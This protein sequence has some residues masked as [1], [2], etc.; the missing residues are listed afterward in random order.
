M[1]SLSD[2]V[3]QIRAIYDSADPAQID[4]ELRC[5]IGLDY[6]AD[7]NCTLEFRAPKEMKP[8]ILIY[9]ELDNFHQNHRSYSKSRN[10]FQL[11]GGDADD[12]AVEACMPLTKLG[13][14]TLNPCGKIANTYFNDVFY[15]ST[16]Q[17]EDGAPLV[18]V[19]EGIAWQSDIQYRFAQPDGFRMK[20][21]PA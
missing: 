7:K 16:G 9:Y 4:T 6:N 21:C 13:N 2:E 14:M 10:D 12:V 11:T 20:E 1:Q 5:S 3:T 18:M 17:D 8:P 15:L 19:E